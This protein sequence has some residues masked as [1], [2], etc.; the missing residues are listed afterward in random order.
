MALKISIDLVPQVIND[1]NAYTE[2]DPV[3]YTQL[4]VYKRQGLHGMVHRRAGRAGQ[5]CQ[6][7][8]DVYK[9]QRQRMPGMTKTISRCLLRSTRSHAGSLAARWSGGS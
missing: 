7:L 9:R 4:D 6:L 3:S 2:D 5:C 1:Y 8:V